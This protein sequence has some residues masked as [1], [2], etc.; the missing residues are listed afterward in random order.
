MSS[1]RA[2]AGRVPGSQ[3]DSGSNSDSDFVDIFDDLEEINGPSEEDTENDSDTVEGADATQPGAADA[4]A[5][6]LNAHDKRPVKDYTHLEVATPGTPWESLTNAMRSYSTNG[7]DSVTILKAKHADGTPAILR[8]F[9]VVENDGNTSYYVVTQPLDEMSRTLNPKGFLT[10]TLAEKVAAGVF[11]GVNMKKPRMCSATALKILSKPAKAAP[12]ARTKKSEACASPKKGGDQSVPSATPKAKRKPA[13]ELAPPSPKRTASAA[14]PSR[15]PKAKR[16]PA[17]EV[18]PP[19]PLRR[20]ETVSKP[21][22][23]AAKRV[24]ELCTVKEVLE[25]PQPP[26]QVDAKLDPLPVPS[27]SVPP[28]PSITLTVT[29]AN[30][31]QLKEVVATLAQT[32]Q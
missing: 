1:S 18:P 13:D 16:K 30:A 24:K 29:S 21:A 27:T 25:P 31:A 17:S 8:A 3:D 22:K 4:K 9:Q 20:N 26:T 19:S 28:P 6:F 10:R 32:F 11:D 15:P 5:L 14:S 7:A 2:A 23:P 12:K